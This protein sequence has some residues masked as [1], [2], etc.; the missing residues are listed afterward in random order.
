MGFSVE[1]MAKINIPYQ[2]DKEALKSTLKQLP[3]VEKLTASV[4]DPLWGYSGQHIYDDAGNVLF[5]T[6]FE[7]IDEN[8]LDAMEIGIV[9]GRGIERDGE[10]V[11]TEEFGRRM[12]L[13]PE[14]IGQLYS[15][16]GFGV[17]LKLV[18]IAKDY[19]LGGFFEELRPI[20]LI[21]GGF[22]GNSY[23]KIKEPFDQNFIK[24]VDFLSG[25]FPA[26]DFAPVKMPEEAIE[27]YSDVRMFRNSALIASVALIFISLMGL[28][29]FAR[30][31]VQRRSKEIAIRKVN[32]AEASDIV[33]LIIA[34]VARIAI[35]AII[36]GVLCAAY[37]GHIWLSNFSVTASHIGLWYILAG[38]TVLILV[39]GCVIAVTYRIANENPVN[40]LK[41]E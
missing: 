34:D 26:Y 15:N 8:F 22:S 33:S 6:R 27:I 37:I 39:T 18:G 14:D 23:L 20:C 30:D 3:Y 4:S 2:L 1:R 40:R 13:T 10:V 7:W 24:L 19:Q 16:K 29:G 12:N 9:A 21:Y 32:G 5:N 41:S 36:L 31:E 38:L 25:T 17:S 28:I 35:P 11:I